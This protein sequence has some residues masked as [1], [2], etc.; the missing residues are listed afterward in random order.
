MSSA[1]IRTREAMEGKM[2]EGEGE[3]LRKKCEREAEDKQSEAR[4]WLPKWRERRRAGLGSYH[5]P[6]SNAVKRQNGEINWFVPLALD[7]CN[8][9]P[10]RRLVLWRGF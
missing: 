5:P 6:E 2:E 9:D 7:D 1:E 4:L 10:Y 3:E 8:L